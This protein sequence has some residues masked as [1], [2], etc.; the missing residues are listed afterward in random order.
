MWDSDDEDDFVVV[1]PHDGRDEATYQ[2]N[3]H[4]AETQA[5]AIGPDFREFVR[6]RIRMS[7]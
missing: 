6:N 3:V 2:I 7:A 1:V 4:D 5:V